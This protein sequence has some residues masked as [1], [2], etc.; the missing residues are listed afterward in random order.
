MRRV[1]KHCAISYI[2]DLNDLYWLQSTR[3]ITPLHSVYVLNA[4]ALTK[5]N[6]VQ[7]LT[8]DLQNYN[9]D[10]AFISETH[11]KAKHSDSVI[12]VPG[13]T[14]YR[15]DR[16][17]CKGGGVAIYVRSTL[18]SNIWTYAADNST[19]ELLWVQ[20]NTI[21]VGALYHPP[22]LLLLPD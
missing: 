11:F 16:V 5:R 17:G 15:R 18:Q 4:A 6:A 13:Y 22:R 2:S 19:Y 1:G 20:I 12:A 3:R 21:I 10:V 9:I 7:L 14:V 8:A